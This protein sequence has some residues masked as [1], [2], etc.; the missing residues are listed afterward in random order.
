MKI[1]KINVSIVEQIA[2]FHLENHFHINSLL[3]SEIIY[4]GV[5]KSS[6]NLPQV[7]HKISSLN[8]FNSK[9]YSMSFLK[10]WI[11]YCISKFMAVDADKLNGVI[12]ED[13]W[14]NWYDKGDFISSHRHL[15][16]TYA[17]VYFVQSTEDHPSLIFDGSDF[18]FE[19]KNGDLIVFNANL[20]HHVEKNMNSTPRITISGNIKS[21]SILAPT[22]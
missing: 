11:S 3:K 9:S 20:R 6:I 4:C 19:G 13:I 17:F 10:G 2:T 15:P 1:E 5:K 16:N 14:A 18:S 12:Y 22:S 7:N 21:N 8:F